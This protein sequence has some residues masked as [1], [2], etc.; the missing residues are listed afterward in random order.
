MARVIYPI[1]RNWRYGGK[2]TKGCTEPGF[3]DRGFERVTIPHTNRRLPWHSF[4]ER[5]YQFVSIYR[6]RLKLPALPADQRVFVDFDGVMTAAAVYLDGK[7][8]GGHLG[9]Y[10]PFSVEL[11]KHLAGRRNHLLAVRVDSRERPDIPPFGGV[12]DYL[13]FGGIYREVRLRVVNRTFIGNVFA[14]P[15]DACSNNRSLLVRCY[16]NHAAHA[17]A[18][19]ALEVRL[20][21]GRTTLARVRRDIGL[22]R[23][24]EQVFE[25]SLEDLPDVE[26]WD[27]DN[28]RLYDVQ[29]RLLD[30]R[31]AVDEVTVRTGFREARFT[32]EGFRLNG[33]V[34]KLRGLNRHQTFP[35]VGQAMPARIQRRDALILRGEL[36]CNI[37]RTSHY[38]QSPH[39]LDCCDE[40]GLLVFEEIPGWQ[41][42]GDEKWQDVAC[43]N[44]AEMI[45]RDWNH[46]SIVLWGVRIN[47]SGDDHD[48]YT[49]TNRIAH[50]LDESR[51]T[52]GVRCFFGS[53]LLEDVYTMNDFNPFELHEPTH[54]LYLN[55]EFCGHMYP[56]KPWD[57]VERA[58]EHVLRHA[59]VHDMLAADKRYAGG[60]GWCA[61]DYN[62]HHQFGSGDRIC[63]HGVCDIFRLPKPAAGLYKSQCDP[64][65]EIVLEAAFPWCLGDWSGGGAKEAVVCSNC[66]TL[67]FYVG[68]KL[69]ATA[70][71][72]R[73]TFPHLKHPPFRCTS[74]TGIWGQ[75]WLPL[76]IDG[77]IK[78]K[79]VISRLFSERGVDDAFEVRAD[80]DELLGDGCDATRVAFRVTDRFGNRRPYATGVIRFH[81]SGPGEL[82]GDNPF[83]LAGGCG[84]VWIRTKEAGGTIRLTA[85]H[86]QLG[87]QKLR[88][89]VRKAPRETC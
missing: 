23:R 39:F 76:R 4:D 60:I 64:A 35:F 75:R 82:I 31:K 80:D 61:F 25:V 78:G 86:P 41:H 77:L 32:P 52:G 44:V 26:L 47:E 1:N 83:A 6:R 71:P 38:P 17:S 43:R 70:R 45:T 88:I 27:I 63:Y 33:R 11:T 2:F 79:V 10:T 28:P 69:N 59:R 56:T 22:D 81:L 89:K 66:D 42:I 9:G 14:Q 54:P 62:T 30:G 53:E 12:I 40:V 48:F 13:T 36:K 16:L 24:T 68:G 20:R 37:V 46:P 21:D 3:N 50:D 74:L 15:V 57:G 58:Q 5:E 49:R 19:M 84:A 8:V 34:L 51:Q 72:D 67:K 7:R 85:T 29:V 73:K 87:E 65:A 18:S 55:T